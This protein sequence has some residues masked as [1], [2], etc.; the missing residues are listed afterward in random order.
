M[1]VRAPPL[2]V[3]T[4][5]ARQPSLCFMW[6]FRKQV[7]EQHPIMYVLGRVAGATARRICRREPICDTIS[8][9]VGLVVP[10]RRHPDRHPHPVSMAAKQTS[11]RVQV[12]ADTGLDNILENQEQRDYAYIM[13]SLKDR[14]KLNG[15]LASM[16]RDGEIDRA[17]ARR[18]EK[19]V[20]VQLGRPIGARSKA[21]KN[22]APRVWT[23]L[24]RTL[25]NIPEN[26]YFEPANA[27]V[28]PARQTMMFC[29]F[30][31]NC[32]EDTPLQRSHAHSDFEGPLHAVFVARAR[33]YGDR[34]ADLVYA[35]RDTFGWATFDPEAPT[36]VTIRSFAQ[37]SAAPKVFSIRLP[38]TAEFMK[39][40]Q[41][42]VVNNCKLRDITLVDDTAGFSQAVWP[43]LQRQ[44][45]DHGLD[46]DSTAFEIP[47]AAAAYASIELPTA[48]DSSPGAAGVGIAASHIS[49]TKPQSS[50]GNSSPASASSPPPIPKVC[51][52]Q[53][54]A[55]RTPT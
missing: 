1:Y 2:F 43:L 6:M 42:S 46:Q 47:D 17:L 10:F 16:L 8:A 53:K 23:S 24:F 45:P 35:N 13:R 3:V 39:Y 30:A 5:V 20:R 15:I 18:E 12:S 31:M 9:F 25:K 22:L 38:F 26:E 33:N 41:I 28:L 54:R 11:S 50:P 49:P 55:K 4:T 32:T 19:E 40:L 7:V 29:L 34:L 14:P 44:H 27:E 36:T 52:P 48:K 37:A 21:M 51:P